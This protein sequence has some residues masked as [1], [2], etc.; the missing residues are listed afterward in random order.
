MAWKISVTFAASALTDIKEMQKWYAE[1]LVPEIGDR[2][3][4]ET[5]EKVEA[6]QAHAGMGR[7]VPEFG[8]ATL[9]ELIHPP[10]RIVPLAPY[11]VTF[12]VSKA[13]TATN[14]SWSLVN[15]NASWIGKLPDTLQ[16]GPL[17]ENNR[18]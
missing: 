12:P 11:S 1:Q 5:I 14:D 3:T 17:N 13:F 2:F 4:R 8:V 6:L 10:F 9:R 16:T 15:G 18:P 7:I